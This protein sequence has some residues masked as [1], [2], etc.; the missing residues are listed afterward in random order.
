MTLP[1]DDP[2]RRCPDISRV[3]EVIGWKPKISLR[4]GPVLTVAYFE[5]ILREE[6]VEVL[7]LALRP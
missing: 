5:E 1:Q 3:R 2:R 6:P 4:E 7:Q